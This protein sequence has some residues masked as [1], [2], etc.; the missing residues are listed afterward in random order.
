M[1]LRKRIAAW[2]L[3]RLKRK[4]WKDAS[5]PMTRVIGEWGAVSGSELFPTHS[6]LAKFLDGVGFSKWKSRFQ[7]PN[8][9]FWK[10]HTED[11]SIAVETAIP[12]VM[13]T[14]RCSENAE[15]WK[16]ELRLRFNPNLE[17]KLRHAKTDEEARVIARVHWTSGS[18][19]EAPPQGSGW[20]S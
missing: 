13:G 20:T 17:A 19:P 12:S 4:V 5:K 18:G 14:F 6:W 8:Q 11:E 7:I 1:S 3:K 2:R 9:R 15:W 10:P 16:T